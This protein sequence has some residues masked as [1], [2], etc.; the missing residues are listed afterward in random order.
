MADSAGISDEDK[1]TVTG[2]NRDDCASTRA[3]RTWLEAV[4]SGLIAQ[5]TTI[6][7]PVPKVAEISE[8]LDDWQ[9]RV[10]SLIARLTGGIPDVVVV[11]TAEEQA[12]WL[13]AFTLDW[14]GREM[15]AV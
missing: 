12:R 1:A 9:K 3:L 2:Y 6:E 11:R 14:H 4:R 5:G 13:L 8:K 15:K 7:R 10:E